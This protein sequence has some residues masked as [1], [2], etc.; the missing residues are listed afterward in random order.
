[1]KLHDDKWII[2]TGGAGFIGSCILRQLNEKGFNNILVVDELGSDEKWKNL[3]GKK[4]SSY[5]HKDKLF[6]W[7]SQAGV[8]NDIEAIIH[9]G[10]CSST[11]EYNA[12]YLME[13][14]F[15]Y[16]VRLAEYAMKHH[17][18]FVYASSAATYGDGSDG[19]DDDPNQLE[20]LKPLNPYGFSK[21]L[22]DLWIKDNGLI[23]AVTGLKFFNV[24]GP[25]EHH[26]GRMASVVFNLFSQMQNEGVIRLFKSNDLK[27]YADG[28]QCRDFIYV[29]DVASIVVDLITQDVFGIYNLGSG[30]A[31]TWNYLAT[32]M[33]SA[34][35]K[36]VNIE[37]QDMPQDL[38]GK[39]QNYTKAEMIRLKRALK[40]LSFTPLHEAI[41]DYIN[42]YIIPNH[43]Y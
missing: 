36:P 15:D 40:S 35:G 22:F 13:N 30:E 11:V 27:H 24:F 42:H 31:Q 34:V 32:G 37:Y 3:V 25:N 14:N 39:Y 26:K 19:F 43:T 17:I 1:M 28:D 10:A 16:S 18:R 8:A 4:F 2:L 38:Q 12:D 6:D 23:N 21:H 9:M 20:Q 29:K 41:S 33:F 5:L 7:L